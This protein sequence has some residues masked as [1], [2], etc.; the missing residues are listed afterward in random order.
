MAEF[1]AD[2]K[3]ICKCLDEEST[4]KWKL[5]L[6]KIAFGKYPTKLELRKIN[7][8]TDRMGTGIGLSDEMWDRAV[9]ALIEMGYGTT[10][11]LEREL[12]KRKSRAEV[13][14][15]FFDD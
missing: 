11:V 7:R 1:T 6:A 8:E 10:E 5:Y 4:S 3:E 14:E 15:G 2:I 13:E 12:D 9:N